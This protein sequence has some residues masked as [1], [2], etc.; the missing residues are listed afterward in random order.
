MQQKIQIEIQGSGVCVVINPPLICNIWIASSPWGLSKRSFKS[1]PRRMG[2][3]AKASHQ[4]SCYL[5]SNQGRPGVE[6][7]NILDQRCWTSCNLFKMHF[8]K[9]YEKQWK[10]RTRMEKTIKQKWKMKCLTVRILEENLGK[11]TLET[12]FRFLSL[13]AWEIF[14]RSRRKVKKWFENSQLSSSDLNGFQK[15]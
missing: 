15:M 7:L 8:E 12:L 10:A 1:L 6:L 4:S 3:R 5:E 9:I 11:L 13:Y 2:F 14:A